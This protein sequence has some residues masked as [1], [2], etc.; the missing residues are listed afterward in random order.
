MTGDDHLSICPECGLIQAG[1][2]DWDDGPRCYWSLG[3]PQAQAQVTKRPGWRLEG[4]RR[5]GRLN[6]ELDALHK[7]HRIAVKT[8]VLLPELERE[9]RRR[10]AEARD[11]AEQVRHPD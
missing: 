4:W 3:H 1:D 10:E 7:M 6:A 2:H 11:W 9:I 8:G 5:F